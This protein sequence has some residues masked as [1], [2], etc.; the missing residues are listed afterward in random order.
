MNAADALRGVRFHRDLKGYRTTEVD[1]YVRTLV[2]RI[3]RGEPVDAREV[4]T[5][6]FRLGWW[7]YQ[8]TGVDQALE[9]VAAALEGRPPAGG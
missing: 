9:Q 7:G 8:I 4:C 3:D 5:V 2:A 1:D 6:E